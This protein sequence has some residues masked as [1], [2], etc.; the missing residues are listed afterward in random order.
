MASVADI[1]DT[2]TESDSYIEDPDPYETSIS[3]EAAF[4]FDRILTVA[5][6]PKLLQP[7]ALRDVCLSSLRLFEASD[8]AHKLQPLLVRSR[9]AY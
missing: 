7:P 9:C 1:L 2:A 6:P 8:V 5:A 3:Q 4:A